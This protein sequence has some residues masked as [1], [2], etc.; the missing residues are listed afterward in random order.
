[1]NAISV[2]YDRVATRPAVR[3][4]T[5]VAAFVL[6]IAATRLL[7]PDGLPMG[8]VVL[9]LHLGALNALV[10]LG[11]VV[12]YRAGKYVNFAQGGIGAAGAV[13]AGKLIANND[14]NYFLAV[15]IGLAASVAIAGAA[16]LAFVKRLF[17]APRLI[18]TVATIGMAQLFSG[19]E[20]AAASFW[21]DPLAVRPN[22]DSPISASYTI[23]RTIFGGAHIAIMIVFPLVLIGLTAFFRYSRYGAAVQ[24][25]AENAD[26]ARLLGISVRRVSLIVWM[27]AG[28]LAGITAVLQAPIVGFT[29][30]AASGP[31]IM[32]RALAPAMLAGMSSLSGTVAAA[33]ALGVMQQAFV[34]NTGSSGFSNLVLLVVIVGALLV[35]RRRATRTVESE[36]ASFAAQALVRPIPRELAGLRLVKSTRRCLI[37][38]AVVVG[39]IIPL[40]LS[41]TQQNLAALIVIYAIAALSLTLLSGQAGQISF[42]HWAFAGFGALLG[43]HLINERGWHYLLTAVAVCLCGALVAVLIG[44]PALRIRGLFLGVVTLAFAVACTGYVFGLKWFQFGGYVRRPVAFGIDFNK[45]LWFYYL[46]FGMLVLTGIVVRNVRVSRWGRHMLAVRDNDRAAAAFGVGSVWPRLAAFATAGFLGAMA[47]YLYMLHQTAVGTR[48]F[49][50]TTSLLL[51]S[52]VV[53]GGMGTVTGGII[54]ALYLR[55][56]QYFAPEIQLV[57]TSLG[58]L[59]VL[60]FLPGGIGGLLFA[61]RDAA[62]RVLARRWGIEVP[63]LT[64]DRGDFGG[65]PGSDGAP[66]VALSDVRLEPSAPTPD[67]VP[68]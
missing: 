27:I 11:L 59:V 10:A 47:G 26:R 44:L 30:G 14:L 51:F 4:P 53:I 5:G 66:D 62:L 6:A 55:G 40:P 64:A 63:S 42:G 28:L 13:I 23:G 25:A 48:S 37:G 67:A 18:L 56:I 60:M 36:E 33:L 20:V 31:D 12:I 9:G 15:A 43:G 57:S 7:A 41:V 38:L 34:W 21:T 19:F 68:G 61:G 58:L 45:D 65:P 22:L 29:F 54:A 52:A 32:L 2:L 39:I 1:V 16:E 46:C 35:R 3:W 8:V 17:E 50:V 24:A 49:P